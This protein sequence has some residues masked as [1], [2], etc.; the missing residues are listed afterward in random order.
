MP[1]EP[2]P[3]P[4]TQTAPTPK[5]NPL[6]MKT[7][8]LAVVVGLIVLGLIFAF[9][10][11][12]QLGDFLKGVPSSPGSSNVT[13][14]ATTSAKPATK[15]ADKDET[16]D[17]KT[18][19]NNT[20]K[21]S[22]RYPDNWE[23]KSTTSDVWKKD[24]EAGN[25]IIFE[26]ENNS[27]LTF[28]IKVDPSIALKL[29]KTENVDASGQKVELEYYTKSDGRKIVVTDYTIGN[30]LSLYKENRF[31]AAMLEANL[32]IFEEELKEFKLILSTFKF[33]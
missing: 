18:Y 12:G 4:Q 17:W 30:S 19:T 29:D 26:N 15:S 25:A 27:R 3:V 7:V 10:F 23:Q 13:K 14:K 9:L 22:F 2:T 28:S 5:E 8:V 16:A 11:R 21:F 20:Y 33:L 24:V 6:N 31:N 32:S 1:E